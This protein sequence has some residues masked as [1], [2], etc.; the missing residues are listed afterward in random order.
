MALVFVDVEATG[1]SPARGVVTEFGAVVY[2]P[3]TKYHKKT[4]HAKIYEAEPDP[5]NP[6]KPVITGDKLA[7]ES[8][9]MITFATWLNEVSPGQAT[10]VSDNPAY[11]WQWIN[12]YFDKY[13]GSNPFGHSARRIGDFWAG[14]NLN[15]SET[16]SWKKLRVTP[17]THNPV[18]DAMGNVE[19]FES[20]LETV[21]VRSNKLVGY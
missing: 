19:A 2:S 15:W 17:H 21:R 16:Q 6:A 7:S 8:R 18:D 12:Y 11:D 14:M 3:N 20:I 4:F 5:D 13:Y 1:L 9:I 10:F